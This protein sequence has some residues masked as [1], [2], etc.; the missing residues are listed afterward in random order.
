MKRLICV[1]LCVCISVTLFTLCEEKQITM[2][3]FKQITATY[4]SKIQN[5]DKTLMIYESVSVSQVGEYFAVYSIQTPTDDCFGIQLTIISHNKA[6]LEIEYIN[7]NGKWNDDIIHLFVSFITELTNHGLSYE[8]VKAAVESMEESDYY[9][10]SRKSNLSWSEDRLLLFYSETF[11]PD[12][13]GMG[14]LIVTE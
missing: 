1:L 12:K 2:E 11:S 6:E 8:E 7:L 3:Q 13:S 14:Y 9:R 5:I 4:N 10:F